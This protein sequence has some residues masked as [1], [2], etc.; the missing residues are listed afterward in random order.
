VVAVLA[1]EL[2]VAGVWVDSA[3]SIVSDP[4]DLV[5]D[6]DWAQRPDAEFQTINAV[7]A[8]LPGAYIRV[9]PGLYITA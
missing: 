8:A 3:P 5:A 6:N 4:N 1:H 9:C 7:T 2:A